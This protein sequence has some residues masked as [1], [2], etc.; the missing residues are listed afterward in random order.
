MI[1]LESANRQARHR[2]CRVAKARITE[3]NLGL[4]VIV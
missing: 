1:S 2:T 4:L 3:L